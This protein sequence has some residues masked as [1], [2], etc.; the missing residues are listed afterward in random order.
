MWLDKKKSSRTLCVIDPGFLIILNHSWKS[1]PDEKNHTSLLVQ[2]QLRPWETVEKLFLC[3]LTWLD[4]GWMKVVG[5]IE[6]R[7]C[8]IWS[9]SPFPPVTEHVFIDQFWIWSVVLCRCLRSSHW[10]ESSVPGTV[11]AFTLSIKYLG[12]WNGRVLLPSRKGVYHENKDIFIVSVNFQ[13][14]FHF[15]LKRSSNP[16]ILKTCFEKDFWPPSP[17]I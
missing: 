12:I 4:E 2:F 16:K 14:Q 1:S 11:P 6:G 10:W 9:C 7:D 3:E 5:A 15:W 8:E 17:D 13:I